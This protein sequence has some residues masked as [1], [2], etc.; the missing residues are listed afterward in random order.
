MK[1]YIIL[2]LLNLLTLN[3]FALD[4]V[5]DFRNLN[6]ADI[7]NDQNSEVDGNNV[8]KHITFIYD[9]A[10]IIVTLR[11]E[12]D[13]PNFL[14]MSFRSNNTEAVY[15]LYKEYLCEYLNNSLSFVGYDNHCKEGIDIYY[16]IYQINKPSYTICST[17]DYSFG[18]FMFGIMSTELDCKYTYKDLEDLWPIDLKV[19]FLDDSL[20]TPE[21]IEEIPTEVIFYKNIKTDET[22][23]INYKDFKIIELE[24][25]KTL[26]KKILFIENENLTGIKISCTDKLKK[27]P[28][29]LTQKVKINDNQIYTMYDLLQNPKCKFDICNK[30]TFSFSVSDE[31]IKEMKKD[32][33]IEVY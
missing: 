1:R 19:G 13:R 11:A 28:E 14:L 30:I 16:K 2:L 20:I 27:N 18:F 17:V 15:N 33:S 10:E 25:N 26:L 23:S 24:N 5:I 3:L 6:P 12:K 7:L 22:S 8:S 4:P 9:D 31:V 32:F 21:D 29:F